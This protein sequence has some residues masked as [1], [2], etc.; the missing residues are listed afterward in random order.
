MISTGDAFPELKSVHLNS[1]KVLLHNIPMFKQHT[2]MSLEKIKSRRTHLPAPPL[3]RDEARPAG[4]C[5]GPR[6]AVVVARCPEGRLG[7]GQ[8]QVC[9]LPS[10]ARG[11]FL[12]SLAVDTGLKA[13][14]CGFSMWGM[15]SAPESSLPPFYFIVLIIFESKGT[16]QLR[17]RWMIECGNFLWFCVCSGPSIKST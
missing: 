17:V 13:P 2:R 16:K 15:V 1:W 9:F 10:D 3:F 4:G 7:V 6:L 5:Q 11:S 8:G 14:A 12:A